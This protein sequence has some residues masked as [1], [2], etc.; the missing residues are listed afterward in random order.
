MC[1]AHPTVL[2]SKK[3]SRL[4]LVS[5]GTATEL[6]LRLVL[7]LRSCL[8]TGLDARLV[9]GWLAVLNAL[10]RCEDAGSLPVDCRGSTMVGMP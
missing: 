2:L 8:S 6:G 1:S 4:L 9:S 5:Y 10:D 7:R 3:T